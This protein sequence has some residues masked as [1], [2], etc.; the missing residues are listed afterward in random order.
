[1]QKREKVANWQEMYD[2]VYKQM[3]EH[4][5]L[6]KKYTPEDIDIMV[7]SSLVAK[8]LD[9]IEFSVSSAR[10]RGAYR[11]YAK[12]MSLIGEPNPMD[13]DEYYTY[14]EKRTR[15]SL[16]KQGFAF[17]LSKAEQEKHEIIVAKN[18]KAAVDEATKYT[19]EALKKIL[20]SS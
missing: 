9:K 2:A 14:L 6:S 10:R 4:K 16:A 13:E 8:A 15:A 7:R 20:T 3:T 11:K 19:A 5:V 1:M 18:K 17:A 12:Q